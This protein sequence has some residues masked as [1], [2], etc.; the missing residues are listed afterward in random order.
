MMLAN[1]FYT[2]GRSTSIKDWY[3]QAGPHY[4]MLAARA[5]KAFLFQFTKTRIPFDSHGI[6]ARVV[7]RNWQISV[8]RGIE[9]LAHPLLMRLV[10][11]RLSPYRLRYLANFLLSSYISEIQ[12]KLFNV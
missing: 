1:V 12:L 4:K 11:G 6:K 2:A 10:L 8:E 9:P 7:R 5:H 3:S